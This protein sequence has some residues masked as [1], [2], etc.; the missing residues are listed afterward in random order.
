V[1]NEELFY[2]WFINEV[3]A[4]SDSSSFAYDFPENGEYEI[5]I[6]V[7]DGELTAEHIWEIIVNSTKINDYVV[8]KNKPRSK[9]PKSV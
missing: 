1:D 3:Q 6:I 9:L 4:E 2:S 7:S 5:K 8:L